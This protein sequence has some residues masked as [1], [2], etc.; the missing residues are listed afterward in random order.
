MTAARTAF[1]DQYHAAL[2]DAAHQFAA[3]T[4]HH[5]DGHTRTNLLPWVQAQAADLHA[6]LLA[7]RVRL[8]PHIGPAPRTL[9]A[10]VWQRWLIVCADCMPALIGDDAEDFTCDR[11]RRPAEPIHPGTVHIGPLLL[12]FGLCTP[13]T[14]R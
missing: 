5:G 14:R 9:Y 2:T 6:A 7:G 4:A 3:L 1:A 10:A 13:C 11:C 8:C 12:T